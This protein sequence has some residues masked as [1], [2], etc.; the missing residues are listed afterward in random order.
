MRG[1]AWCGMVRSGEAWLG[2]ARHARVR[3]GA[4]RQG[5]A[6]AFLH[7]LNRE[8]RMKDVVVEIRGISPLLMH[9]FPL[10]PTEGLEKKT[11]EDQAKVSLYTDTDGPFIPGVN[12]QRAL[13]AAAAFSKGKGRASLQKVVAAGLFVIEANCRLISESSWSVDSRAVVIAA[14]KGRIVRHRPRFDRWETTFTLSYDDTLLKE[15]E[16]RRVVD[17]AGQKVGL[18]DFRP[19]KK[20]PFG[21]FM[22]TEWAA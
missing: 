8:I 1:E 7:T 22:V 11:P 5:E 18:L 16:V 13:V 17:D 21:R 9:R 12:I 15:S 2:A 14:T 10:E 19:E 20:G 3:L 6:R 4:A